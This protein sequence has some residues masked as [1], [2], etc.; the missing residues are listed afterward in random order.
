MTKKAAIQSLP[1]AVREFF[2]RT[3]KMSAE[4]M[5]PEQRKERGRKG[6]IAS[7]EARRRKKAEREA[8]S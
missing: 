1:K 5:T 6:G 4:A 7:G 3:G 8:Q 2:V